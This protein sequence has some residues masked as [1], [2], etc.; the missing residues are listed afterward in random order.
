ME[1]PLILRVSVAVNGDDAHGWAGRVRDDDR[2]GQRHAGRWRG[3]IAAAEKR[4]SG[5][6][7]TR[8]WERAE[9]TG[10][11]FEEE[12]KGGKNMF[13]DTKSG[14]YQPVPILSPSGLHLLPLL[15]GPG[16]SR[17]SR[18]EFKINPFNLGRCKSSQQIEKRPFRHQ[19]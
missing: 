13:S 3:D 9:G 8:T 12:K 7:P 5:R 16:L 4:S 10:F 2:L 6:T 11:H 17:A 15:L 14:G 18:K 1:L 19:A